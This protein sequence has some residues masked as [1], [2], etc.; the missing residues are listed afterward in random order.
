[1]P[2]VATR[3][4][5]LLSIVMSAA[6]MLLIGPA[7]AQTG[8]AAEGDIAGSNPLT[9]DRGGV[10]ENEFVETCSAEP[11]SQGADGWVVELP[12]SFA[13]GGALATATGESAAEYDLDLA[14]YDAECVFIE[15]AATAAVDESAPLPPTTRFV[16]VNQFIGA[17]THFCLVVGVAEC[18][19]EA[20]PTGSASGS[21]SGTA[22]P[23]GSP[24]GSGDDISTSIT[25]D[26]TTTKYRAPFVLSGR[27][28][29]DGSCERP[30][31]VTIRK[32]QLGS[33]QYRSLKERTPVGKDNRWSREVSSKVSASYVARV[34]DSGACGSGSSR[35]ITVRVRAKVRV[36]VPDTCAAPQRVTGRVRANH[37]RSRVVLERR[38]ANGWATAD[39]D[40]LDAKSRF[41]VSAPSCSPRFRVV[42]PSSDPRNARGVTAFEF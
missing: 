3:I 37:P 21:S 7:G 16:V 9:S 10:T 23:S 33:D 34:D 19:G 6:A 13:T 27:V 25:T 30:F 35:P 2:R 15:Q 5:L 42:W 36:N 29:A 38:S 31:H 17:D 41:V 1:M 14:F 12:E 11:A 4:A 22:S 28:D 20:S 40:R 18:T 8:F 32:R 26:R 24:S 39:R